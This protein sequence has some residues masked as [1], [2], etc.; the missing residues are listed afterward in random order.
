MRSDLHL[1]RK[2]WHVA[3]GLCGLW[4]HETFQLTAHE[5][6]SVLLV[7]SG[8]GF[9]IDFVR[10]RWGSFNEL[11]LKVMKNFMRESERFGYSGLPFYA[12]GVSLALFFFQEKLAILAVLFL[13]FSDPISS[14]VGI[15]YGQEKVLPNKSLQGSLA[16]FL[17]CY[18]L[19]VTYA[20]H[21]LDSP[22]LFN[23]LVFSILA[24][25]I[26]MTSELASASRRVDDNLSIPLLSALG[27]SF[28]NSLI[29]LY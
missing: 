23:V 18:F 6:A 26:G 13:I 25:L 8:L 16:G 11:V 21:H 3:T 7:V 4:V 14:I 2:V 17:A 9:S 27:L 22:N 24:G 10:L 5:T 1:L 19:S 20:I 15:V 29:P 12:L 28:I